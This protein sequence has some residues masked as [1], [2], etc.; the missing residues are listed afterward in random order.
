MNQDN[1]QAQVIKIIRLVINK[2][3]GTN[4]I[5]KAIILMAQISGIDLLTVAYNKM[6]ILKYQSDKVSGEEFV[7]NTVLPRVLNKCHQI[8]FDVGANIGN[9]SKKLKTNFNQATIYSFEPNIF[10]YKKLKENLDS[11]DINCYNLG[12][13]S[14]SS[15]K[16]IYT[17]ADQLDSE[18]AS[19]YREVI[20]DIHHSNSLVETEFNAVSIDQFCQN[21]SIEYIDFLKIDT[22]GHDYEV[23]KGAIGMIKEDKIGIIQFEFN[24]MNVVSR[25]FLKDFYCL[26]EN[27]LIYRIDS[28]RIIPVWVYSFDNEIFKFQNFLAIHKNL[29]LNI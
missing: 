5:K 29:N 3:L 1:W 19:V 27:Y 24:E 2:I 11:L 12:L 16:K 22:E 4:N 7:I 28:Q 10:T 6:G 9:F 13:S 20:T 25:V 14:Q 26:L 21:N 15:T 17:Y 23:L 18:H 8:F